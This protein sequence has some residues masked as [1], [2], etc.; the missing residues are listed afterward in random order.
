M[1]APFKPTTFYYLD[2]DGSSAG[3]AED[4]RV[5]WLSLGRWFDS[6]SSEFFYLNKFSFII[7]FNLYLKYFFYKSN[8]LMIIYLSAVHLRW[9]NP[10]KRNKQWRLHNDREDLFEI[11][12]WIRNLRNAVYR[13][14]KL[15][16]WAHIWFSLSINLTLNFSI[17]REDKPKVKIW[18]IHVLTRKSRFAKHHYKNNGQREIKTIRHALFQRCHVK[19]SKQNITNGLGLNSVVLH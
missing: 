15:G 7:C 18:V 10:I 14:W 12:A 13:R 2:S 4:C 3:R 19:R 8:H 9:W 16:R 11:M 17:W 5:L 1:I 6:G